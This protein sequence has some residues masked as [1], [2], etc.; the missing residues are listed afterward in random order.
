MCQHTIGVRVNWWSVHTNVFAVMHDQHYI[1]DSVA[2]GISSR[3]DGMG[4]SVSSDQ[5]SITCEE[6]R[7]IDPNESEHR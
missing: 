3:Q 1:E 7:V 5:V 2:A 4:K 6:T